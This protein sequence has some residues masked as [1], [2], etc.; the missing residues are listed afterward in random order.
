[1]RLYSP[2]MEAREA[3]TG[4][5]QQGKATVWRGVTE[6]RA[7]LRTV[8]HASDLDSPGTPAP[9]PQLDVDEMRRRRL[10]RFGGGA[11][12]GPPQ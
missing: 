4:L 11:G 1:M 7:Y 5:L 2:T 6:H 10:A 3:M 8:N 9:A 12:A